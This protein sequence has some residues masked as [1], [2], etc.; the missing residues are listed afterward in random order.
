MLKFTGSPCTDF[1]P[2]FFSSSSR[3]M[4]QLQMID[5]LL[6][7]FI[8]SGCYINLYVFLLSPRLWF[9][10]SCRV[11]WAELSI[12]GCCPFVRISF[13]CLWYFVISMGFAMIINHKF[14]CIQLKWQTIHTQTH[15]KKGISR[16]FFSLFSSSSIL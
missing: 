4:Q 3:C 6:S 7:S 2:F 16:I 13:V 12:V 11:S 8:S 10:L 15:T 1:K 9:A 14:I 5:Y